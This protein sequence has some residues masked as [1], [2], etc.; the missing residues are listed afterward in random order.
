MPEI[1]PTVGYRVFYWPTEDDKLDRLGEDG[2]V[3]PGM[4]YT[5]PD[6]PLMGSI[7][8]INAEGTLGIFVID[9]ANKKHTRQRVEIIRHEGETHEGIDVAGK[10]ELFDHGVRHNSGVFVPLPKLSRSKQ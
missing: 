1:T 10:A 8:H 6:E 5:N 4:V 9:E 2:L 3:R 7:H